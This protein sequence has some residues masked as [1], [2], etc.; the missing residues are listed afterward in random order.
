MHGR[1]FEKGDFIDVWE[2]GDI[3]EEYQW[4]F[5]KENANSEE[6]PDSLTLGGIVSDSDDSD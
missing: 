2:E 5:E 4:I 6:T 1:A 3:K